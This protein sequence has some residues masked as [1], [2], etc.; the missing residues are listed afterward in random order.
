MGGQR[1]AEGDDESLAGC[2]EGCH[3]MRVLKAEWH[4]SWCIRGPGTVI[5]GRMNGM[6]RR[7]HV[8]DAQQSFTE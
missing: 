6:C 5:P 8:A 3:V 2:A 1:A 7:V 4:S